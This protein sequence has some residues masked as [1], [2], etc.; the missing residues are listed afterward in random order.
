MDPTEVVFEVRQSQP[1][2]EIWWVCWSCVRLGT[3]FGETRAESRAAVLA[4]AARHILRHV[5]NTAYDSP[6]DD[7]D[8]EHLARTCEEVSSEQL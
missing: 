7:G 4:A 1:D 5:T 8:Y 2:E 6:S 3:G